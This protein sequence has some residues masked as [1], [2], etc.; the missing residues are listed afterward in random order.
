[1]PESIR[2]ELR[3]DDKGTATIKNFTSSTSKLDKSVAASTTG[4]GKWRTGMTQTTKSMS[5]LMKMV[6]GLAGVAGIGM[7]SKSVLKLGANFEHS[8]LTVGGVM[9]ATDEEFKMLEESAREMGATTEWSATQS[10]DALQF[11]GMAGFDATKAISSLPG[12]LDLATAGNLDLGRAAD[13]ASNAM[14]AMGMTTNE[15]SRINDVFIG[16]IT[17]TNTN[18]E[19]M[20]ESFKYAAPVAKAYGYEV[21]ELSAMIGVLGNAGIQGSM[22]GTQLSFAITRVGDAFEAAGMSGEGKNLVDALELI[23][24]QGWGAEKVMEVFGQRAGRS[25][26][27]LKDLVPEVRNLTDE[28][29]SAEGEAKTLADT[30]RSSLQSEF[31]VL[32]SVLQDQALAVFENNKDAIKGLVQDTTKWIQLHGPETQ[33]TIQT[34]ISLVGGIGKAFHAVGTGLGV[35][36][37]KIWE[38]IDSIDNAPALDIKVDLD[39]IESAE[40][41][42]AKLAYA[43]RYEGEAWEAFGATAVE[44]SQQV[45]DAVTK[46]AEKQNQLVERS[47]EDMNRERD[48]KIS[49]LEG[50]AGYEAEVYALKSEL[51][52]QEKQSYIDLYGEKTWIVDAFAQKQRD[53]AAEGAEQLTTSIAQL[54]EALDE[55]LELRGMMI[56]EVTLRDREYFEAKMSALDNWYKQELLKYQGNEEAKK[57]VQEVYGKKRAALQKAIDDDTVKAAKTREEG[58]NAI[59]QAGSMKGFEILKAAALPEIYTSTEAGAIAAYK[60]LAGIPIIGP[61]LGAAAAAAVVAYGA[62][63]AATVMGLSIAHEGL[64]YVPRESPYLLDRGERVLSADQ[65]QDLMDFLSRQ[66]T[67]APTVLQQIQG[68]GAGGVTTAE[69]VMSVEALRA[70]IEG[71]SD[72]PVRIAVEFEGE[73]LKE[74]LYEATKSGE[75][76]I[77]ERGL[78]DL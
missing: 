70:A 44:V 40:M 69:L 65:N 22:A 10:A 21:E 25:V 57:K 35:A 45:K 64:E 52:E 50:M 36:A 60:A 71:M 38:F 61:A 9:R 32:I 53:L 23:T 66:T 43:V 74:Y 51:L 27:V 28:L 2:F 75:P 63:R 39:Q 13:I 77:H 42:M 4:M 48:L 41:K 24:E 55:E 14:S 30:M 47:I 56:E 20:G 54:T 78:T 68:V 7:L 16:T 3:V 19:M 37:A 11:L 12:V 72:R 62:K 46:R 15:L 29:E 73:T 31:K 6:L 49:L 5:G 17:R 1:M 58:L 67:T 33:Q 59:A 18:M 26:L 34:F 8:M 76:I